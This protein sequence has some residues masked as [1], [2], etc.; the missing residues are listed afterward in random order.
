MVGSPIVVSES[1][2]NYS[3][4]LLKVDSFP[5][6]EL[7]LLNLLNIVKLRYMLVLPVM[8]VHD[9]GGLC[10][11]PEVSGSRVRTVCVWCH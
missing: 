10:S 7:V 3:L 9:S 11:L 1:R 8:N 5:L 6:S 2:M 4:T